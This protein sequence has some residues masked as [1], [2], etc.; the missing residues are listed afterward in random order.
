[1]LLRRIRGIAGS[2]IVWAF[3]WLPLG[4]VLAASLRAPEE[5]LYCQRHW[6]LLILALWTGWGAAS[7]L[8]FGLLLMVLERTRTLQGLSLVRTAMWGALAA[9]LLPGLLTLVDVMTLPTLGAYEWG[10]SITLLVSALAV[11]GGSAVVTLRLA[12]RGVSLEPAA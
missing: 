4:G 12:K 9:L 7:G 11:G 1:M 5:C 2:A 8:V 6:R 3:L 10:P